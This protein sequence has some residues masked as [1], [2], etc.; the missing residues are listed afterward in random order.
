M[1]LIPLFAIFM[2][3]GGGGLVYKIIENMN[4]TR[5]EIA[6]LRAAQPGAQGAGISQAEL[7]AL[8]EEV[9]SLRQQIHELRDTTMQYDLSFDAA[10]QRLERR[11]EQTEQPQR[12]TQGLG[13]AG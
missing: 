12:L 8:R 13:N 1:D 3:F 10:L 11:V 9:A 6:R 4:N 7:N 2:I 5:L